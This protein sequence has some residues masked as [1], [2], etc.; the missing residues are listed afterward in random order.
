MKHEATLQLINQC[1]ESIAS[2]Q[3]DVAITL[4][5]SHEGGKYNSTFASYANRINRLKEEQNQGVIDPATYDLRMNQINA[6]LIKTLEAWKE[7]PGGSPG[8]S[9]MWLWMGG[10]GIA[11]AALL[12]WWLVMP[13][14]TCTPENKVAIHVADFIPDDS[15]DPLSDL[16]YYALEDGLTDDQ[17]A[18][19][20][21]TYI[22][23][24]DTQQLARYRQTHFEGK[25]DREGLIVNGDYYKDEKLFTCHIHMVK[26]AFKVND[27]GEGQE[28]YNLRNPKDL[29]LDFVEQADLIAQ[30]I[31]A[32]LQTFAA[33]NLDE[34]NAAVTALDQ[35]VHSEIARSDNKIKGAA[36]FYKAVAQTMKGEVDEAKSSFTQAKRL[37]AK[38]A[39]TIT[40]NLDYVAAVEAIQAQKPD[41]APIADPQYEIPEEGPTPEALFQALDQT[42]TS[43]VIAFLEAYPDHPEA[44]ALQKVLYDLRAEAAYATLNQSDTLAVMAFLKAFP[45]HPSADDLIAQ[46]ADS[47]EAAAFLALNWKDTS[48]IVD[49]LAAYPDHSETQVLKDTLYQLRATAAWMPIRETTEVE[50]LQQFI[51]QYPKSSYRQAAENRLIALQWDELQKNATESGLKSVHR[52]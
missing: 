2:G 3:T 28:K 32:I 44:E 22:D 31:Y 36:L 35:I 52:Q 13:K 10:V 46:M 25:C 47:K 21:T 12:G 41:Y 48:Q 8:R 20:S 9:R 24:K 37:D 18:I 5:R 19:R 38:L 50:A 33:E 11:L 30:F 42:D 34:V 17:Y 40:E 51:D 4:L 23:D 43:A 7:N 49:F 15:K 29:E 39:T 1:L 45:D 27:L 14:N 16:L 6:A 26:L